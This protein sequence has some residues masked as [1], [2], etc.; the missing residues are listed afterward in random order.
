MDHSEYIIYN[1]ILAT[2]IFNPDI[3]KVENLLTLI[4]LYINAF[5]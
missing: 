5:Q 2:E 1:T 4:V 3:R